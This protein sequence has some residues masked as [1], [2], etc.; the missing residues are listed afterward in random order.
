MDAAI[1]QESSRDNSYARE[2]RVPDE[3]IW[4]SV[5]WGS[6]TAGGSGRGSIR[7]EQPV[8]IDLRGIDALEE[9]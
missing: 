5:A 8:D 2:T 9:L 1:R 4:S 7:P 6:I 3:G